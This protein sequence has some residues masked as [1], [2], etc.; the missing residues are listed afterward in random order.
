MVSEDNQ[1]RF[2][3]DS[4]NLNLFNVGLMQLVISKIF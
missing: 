2:Q 4:N 3:I 1:E